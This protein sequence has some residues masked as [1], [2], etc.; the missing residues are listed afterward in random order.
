MP[1]TLLVAAGGAFV[2]PLSVHGQHGLALTARSVLTTKPMFAEGRA[3]VVLFSAPPEYDD[4]LGLSRLYA[5]SNIA[6]VSL[7][8]LQMGFLLCAIPI[9]DWATV[10]LFAV[11]LLDVVSTLGKTLDAATCLTDASAY[12]RDSAEY[13]RC[14]QAGA[15]KVEAGEMTASELALFKPP[16]FAPD[17][18][19]RVAP[20]VA[21]ELFHF[22][23]L[24]TQ[25]ASAF[26]FVFGEQ[27]WPT[28]NEIKA[29]LLGIKDRLEGFGEE[30]FI[31]HYGSAPRTPNLQ[32]N[33][34]TG[35]PHRQGGSPDY[36]PTDTL[37]VMQGVYTLNLNLMFFLLLTLDN[38]SNAF[39]INAWVFVLLVR[40]YEDRGSII[41][42]LSGNAYLLKVDACGCE[43]RG[44]E[45]RVQ[46]EARKAQVGVSDQLLVE[47][48]P[49]TM[50]QPIIPHVAR[51]FRFQATVGALASVF[52]GGEVL[53]GVVPA[54][55]IETFVGPWGDSSYGPATTVDHFELGPHIDI[56]KE[57]WASIDTYNR[58]TRDNR[59]T[60]GT[61]SAPTRKVEK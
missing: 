20:S 55:E 15:L 58:R 31:T 57:A 34:I 3:H 30:S 47:H 29:S 19:F 18:A 60:W 7:V 9:A 33:E 16:S 4:Q 1:W 23:A 35:A 14:V 5:A 6:F 44:Y 52:N 32:L 13:E 54:S 39:L 17:R 41:V 25:L 12:S 37:R 38:A 61:T 8:S 36:F 59:R 24:V 46:A 48:A 10:F 2:T 11:Y 27:Q 26:V 56:I 28:M 42:I 53:A 43:S 50:I 40:F 22:Q 51:L 49:P 21:P 45:Q